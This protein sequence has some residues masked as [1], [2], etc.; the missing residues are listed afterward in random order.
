MEANIAPRKRKW[1]VESSTGAGASSAPLVQG[2]P[3][4]VSAFTLVHAPIM[5][6]LPAGVTITQPRPV[7]SAPPSL[8]DAVKMAQE[9]AGDIPSLLCH[10]IAPSHLDR[11]STIMNLF[12]VV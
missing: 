8:A 6:G 4:P 9:A 11:F 10:L 1:D 7:A 3:P 2:F 12:I 5:L